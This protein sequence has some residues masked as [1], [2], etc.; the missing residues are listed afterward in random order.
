MESLIDT[1]KTTTVGFTASQ[2][3]CMQILPDIISVFVG[4]ATF[5]YLVIKIRKELYG[6]K[7]NN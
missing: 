3:T 6:K 2:V 4:L 1:L 5:V 7:G